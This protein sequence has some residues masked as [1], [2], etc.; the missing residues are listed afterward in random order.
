MDDG[1]HV[2]D[3]FLR[4]PVVPGQDRYPVLLCQEIDDNIQN[5]TRNFEDSSEA[6]PMSKISGTG[7]CIAMCNS[8]QPLGRNLGVLGVFF[9]A[10]SC[11][12]FLISGISQGL[13][14]VTHNVLAG[15]D[16]QSSYLIH[17]GKKRGV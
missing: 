8:D 1:L 7:T 14:L 16:L 6:V 4:L 17:V 11:F 2:F 12:G 9:T 3:S 13:L 15:P 5:D 10:S